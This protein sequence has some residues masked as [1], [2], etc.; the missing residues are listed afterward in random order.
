MSFFSR[1]G[2]TPF[3]NHPPSL[4]NLLL[5]ITVC[6]ISFRCRFVFFVNFR[7][8]V[9]YGLGLGIGFGIGI[10]NLKIFDRWRCRHSG[11]FRPLDACPLSIQKSPIHKA[12]EV[13]SNS[14]Q[15]DI[16]SIATQNLVYNP[17]FLLCFTWNY[18]MRVRSMECR[19]SVAYN[20]VT[21]NNILL[22]VSHYACHLSVNFGS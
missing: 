4:G 19:C 9:R 7:V 10:G 16:S 11:R 2:Y 21:C 8:R 15:R 5:D 1:S 17:C 22:Y 20:A 3:I 14:Q 6:S 18:S 12:L 13:R